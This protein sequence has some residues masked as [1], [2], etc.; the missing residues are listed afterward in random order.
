MRLL[1][2]DMEAQRSG[3]VT[4]TFA[5]CLPFQKSD[6]FQIPVFSITLNYCNKIHLFEKHRLPIQIEIVTLK[7]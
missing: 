3:Y 4:A 6:D 2:F 7:F 1:S 5:F